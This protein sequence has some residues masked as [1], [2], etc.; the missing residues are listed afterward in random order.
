MQ[1]TKR[2][3]RRQPS[4]TFPSRE[5]IS[6]NPFNTPV[7]L[8]TLSEDGSMGAQYDGDAR[9]RREQVSSSFGP[10]RRDEIPVVEPS[11]YWG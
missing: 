9:R 8:H 7:I 1:P 4:P 5:K 10:S 11:I 3:A 2:P 6:F